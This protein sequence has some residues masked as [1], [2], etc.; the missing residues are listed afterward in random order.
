MPSIQETAYPRLKRNLSAKEL[1]AIYTPTPEELLLAR[2]ET[3]GRV[4]RL[5]FLIL[6][7]TFQRVGYAT[8][9]A[10]VLARIIRQVAVNVQRSISS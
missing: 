7:K 5:G 3:K 6:L 2:R 10:S 9:A 1:V 4:P 8:P